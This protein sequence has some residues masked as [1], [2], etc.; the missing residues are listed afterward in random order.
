MI[1]KLNGKLSWSSENKI[2][3]DVSGVG[4]IVEI[5]ENLSVPTIG[6]NIEL[7]IYTHVREDVIE[8][9]GFKKIEHRSLFEML[10]SVSRIGPKA[11]LKILSYLSYNRFIQAILTENIS[12]LKEIKGIGPKTAQRLVL[13]LKSKINNLPHSTE[14]TQDINKHTEEL[15]TALN[16]LGYSRPEIN[17]ALSE[18][19]LDSQISLEDKIKKV[20]SYLGKEK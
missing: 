4:Y 14:K 7:F 20:L 17:K 6:K 10:L 19:E 8:L 13:E 11:A 3:I 2:L 12:T 15:Y 18:L 1:G 16:N 9:Y 5:P